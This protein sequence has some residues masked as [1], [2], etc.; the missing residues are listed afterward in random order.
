[1][2][3][4]LLSRK[5]LL[6]LWL[7][8]A[9]ATPLLLLAMFVQMAFGSPVRGKSVALLYD[10]CGNDALGGTVGLSISEQVGN[11]LVRGRPWAKYAAAIIDALMGAGHTRSNATIP[12]QP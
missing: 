8:C 11:A 4:P 10:R 12:P 5:Q 7:V 3:A 9:M 6:G 1:M 2:V